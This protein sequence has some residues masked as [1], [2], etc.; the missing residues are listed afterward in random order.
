[1]LYHRISGIYIICDKCHSTIRT[2][3]DHMMTKKAIE[4]Y[5][6]KKSYCGRCIQK[7]IHRGNEDWDYDKEFSC[8][9]VPI[10]YSEEYEKNLDLLLSCMM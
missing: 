3:Y 8:K 1:M 5:K 10:E 6:N 2:N 9:D 4:K 7:R